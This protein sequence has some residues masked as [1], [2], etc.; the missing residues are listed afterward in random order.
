[1]DHDDANVASRDDASLCDEDL[2]DFQEE[3]RFGE[4]YV[5]T[6]KTISQEIKPYFLKPGFKP[7]TGPMLIEFEDFSK[8]YYDEIPPNSSS[9]L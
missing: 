6:S 8:K 9:T 1:M 2:G 5:D 3:P 7:E 4:E